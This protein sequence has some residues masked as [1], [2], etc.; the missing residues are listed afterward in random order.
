MKPKLKYTDKLPVY[1]VSC[2]NL[3]KATNQQYNWLK[4]YGCEHRH[5]FTNHF[6]CFLKKY[7]IEEKIAYLDTEFYVGKNRWGGLASEW[8]FILCWVIGDGKGNYWYDVIRPNEVTT[9]RDTRILETLINVL[10]RFDRVIHHYGDRADLPLIRTRALIQGIEFPGYG[11]LFTTDLWK[12][13]KSKFALSSNSQ[14]N[15]AEAFLKKTEKTRVESKLWLAAIQG[16]KKALHFIL[17]HCKADV[18][19]LERNAKVLLP[20]VRLSKT[21]I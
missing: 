19:D 15:I 7:N 13:A 11:E 1:M 2:T 5:N 20:F 3:K 16:D 12:I 17:E 4:A 8:G 10:K 6:N 18:R 14:K 21:S 9:S